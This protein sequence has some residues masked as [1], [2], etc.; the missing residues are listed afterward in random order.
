VHGLA[1]ITGGGVL[2]LLRLGSGV[3]YEI[4]DPLPVSPVFELIARCGSVEPAEMQKVFN[5]GCGFV[6]IVPEDRADEAAAILGAHHPGAARIGAVTGEAGRVS[7]AGV[8]AG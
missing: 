4:S 2:N 1:H 5:M 3:G 7:V 6:A 8:S